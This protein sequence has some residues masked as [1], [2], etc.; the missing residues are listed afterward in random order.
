MKT[1]IRSILSLLFLVLSLV[2]LITGSIRWSLLSRTAWRQALAK[3][4]A[5]EQL[6]DSVGEFID[7]RIN[8]DAIVKLRVERDAGRLSPSKRAEADKL[9]ESV[10]ALTGVKEKL[11]GGM[12]V[13]IM[14]SNL[15]R[16]FKFLRTK[17]DSLILDLPLTELGVPAELLAETNLTAWNGEV[18]FIELMTTDKN[19]AAMAEM[20]NQ[21]KQIQS[22]V[23][24]VNFVCIGSGLA[25]ALVAVGHFALGKD[26]ARK[27]RGTS[28]LLVIS[29]GLSLGLTG[30][31]INMIK[32]MMASLTK[33]SPL[34]QG[35]A[36]TM[37]NRIMGAMKFGGWSMFVIGILGVVAVYYLLKTGKLAIEKIKLSAE[38]ASQR[39]KKRIIVFGISLLAMG[40]M[41]FMSFRAVKNLV[42]Q[43][44]AV[45]LELE[46]QNGK[47][48]S[49]YG[50]KLFVPQGWGLKELPNY[51]TD[52]LTVPD[53]NPGDEGWVYVAVEP[54]ARQDSVNQG[55]FMK[56]LEQILSDDLAEQNF[57]LIKN[58][59]TN[60][61]GGW[62]SYD[63]WFKTDYQ[64]QQL[65]QFRR[66]IFPQK[67]GDGWLIYSQTRADEWQQ[68]EPQIMK[69]VASFEVAET[70]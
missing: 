16:I 17:Q 40:L 33:S 25:M 22:L 34:F 15:N 35:L 5:Y 46:L 69:V 7:E 9:L 49:Q 2:F 29:G 14:D 52:M 8:S 64:E 32:P 36:T 48:H 59:T 42:Q 50:W 54:F 21:L 41:A 43:N 18:D 10:D 37:I 56:S 66:Y 27:I 55:G 53:K 60:Q 26:L 68:F 39:R 4:G 31:I 24:T 1:F 51:N 65:N 30:L 38:E 57:V 20:K 3:S 58:P 61:Q 12:M 63:F 11:A 45:N 47:Y 67:E 44:E 19:Q 6:S 23:R 62:I 13:K 28:W 70:E